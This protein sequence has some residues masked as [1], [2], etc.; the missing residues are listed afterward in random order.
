MSASG[1]TK[2]IVAA[3]LANLGIAITKF[4]AFLLTGSSSMLAES[5]HSVA[6]SGNQGLLLVGGRAGP[7]RGHPASTP[8]ATAASAT[9]TP[10]SSPSCCSAS[11]ACSR[12]T[13]ATT[14]SQHPEPIDAWQWVPVVVLVVAIVLETLLLPHR[15]RGVQP[16]PRRP[17]LGAVRPARQGARAARRPAGGPRRAGR[18]GPRA[19]RCRPDAR[20][21]TTACGTASAPSASA[22]CSCSSPSCSRSRPRA[23][24]SAR[25]PPRRP[26]GGSR[27][28][29]SA[30]DSVRRIIHMKTLHLGPEELLVAAKIAVAPDGQRGRGRRARSTRPRC[31]SARPCRSRG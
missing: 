2:A 18:P 29:W 4:I 28:R 12:S 5:I 15:D 24:C 31:G 22:S 14:S 26:W 25:A 7:P 30:D 17:S 19:L 16:G 11:A 3:L 10:S 20:S 27:R 9:S 1:G 23:C 6:D 13:R 21:P 8:S